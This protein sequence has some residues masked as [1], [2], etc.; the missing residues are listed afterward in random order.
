MASKTTIYYFES[1]L[2]QLLLSTT[3]MTCNS[4]SIIGYIL[5][6]FPDRVTQQGILNVGLSGQ[7]LIY[8]TRKITIKRGGH[9]ELKFRSL[10][11]HTV[12]L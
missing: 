2:K 10:K 12:W 8:C 4:S 5:V 7:H 3:R 6:R 1:S 11:N 9:K